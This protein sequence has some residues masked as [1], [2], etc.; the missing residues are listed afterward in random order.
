MTDRSS[1][2][3]SAIVHAS[4][5]TRIGVASLRDL[6]V[7]DV[8][9]VVRYW[10]ESGDEHLD[11]LGIDRARLGTREDT[12]QRFLRALG[13]GDPAQPAMAFAITLDGALVGYTLLNQY[14]A[15]TN[16][17]HW[18]IIVPHR[19][20]AGLSSA[21]YP[22]RIQMYFALT[23]MQRLTHQTRTRNVGVNRM[24]DRY[25]AVAETRHIDTPDGVAQP[26][27]FHLR[28]VHR[29]DVPRLFRIAAE[30]AGT[31]SAPRR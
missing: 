5:H 4:V 31:D 8:A 26:G 21:L 25:V 27:E 15:D 9:A 1:S 16:Y 14:A 17:S 7:G 23:A 11:A 10:H 2:D 6:H 20:A 12:R 18:H 28:Y 19:R 24:L 13:D 29:D 22:H 30:W 3:A